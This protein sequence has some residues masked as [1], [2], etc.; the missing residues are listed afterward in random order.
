MYAVHIRGR[1]VHPILTYHDALASPC[2]ATSR[3]ARRYV[4]TAAIG[5]GTRRATLWRPG[6]STR[7]QVRNLREIAAAGVCSGSR[8]TRS[9][10]SRVVRRRW[11]VAIDRPG[12]SS[13]GQMF[14][15][16]DLASQRTALRVLRLGARVRAADLPA[17][18]PARYRGGTG[19]PSGT[20]AGARL[21]A[22]TG[23]IWLRLRPARRWSRSVRT[24]P[25]NNAQ[26]PTPT[27]DAVALRRGMRIDCRGGYVGR[28]EGF[29]VDTQHGVVTQ[30]LV[31]VRGD[32]EA[33]VQWPTDPLAPLLPLRGQRALLAP[34][35]VTKADRVAGALPFLPPTP[36]LILDATPAQVAAS[37][38]LR[39]DAELTADVWNMLAA[40]PAI[41]PLTPRLRVSVHDGVVTLLGNMP[42]ARHR[43]SAEQDIW[44]VPGVLGVNNEVRIGA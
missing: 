35:W 17:T 4:I 24:L 39:D 40:N 21:R 38:I 41:A 10:D 43:L 20:L 14:S 7:H 3:P 29:V 18:I 42:S 13:G 1:I 15:E 22:R 12:A 11:I 31:R 36:R 2:I 25:L 27:P 8:A 5:N 26:P 23:E 9:T 28:L 37:L 30:L 34:S 33:D 19:G 44:H 16:R 32:V 6:H